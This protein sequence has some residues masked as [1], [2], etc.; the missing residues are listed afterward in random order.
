MRYSIKKLEEQGFILPD[1]DNKRKKLLQNK[2]KELF[3]HCEVL[4]GKELDK[5][6][7]KAFGAVIQYIYK[8]NL[9]DDN[10]LDIIVLYNKLVKFVNDFWSTEEVCGSEGCFLIID[11]LLGQYIVV[12]N[13][14]NNNNNKG[15]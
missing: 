11:V 6:E 8:I 9:I 10:T 7:E 3:S 5:Y 13:N 1:I 14:N 12:L 4:N 15:N 2:Y